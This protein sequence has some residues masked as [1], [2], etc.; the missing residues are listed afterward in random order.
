M[1]RRMLTLVGLFIATSAFLARAQRAEPV[2]VKLPLADLPFS[3]SDWRGQDE[4]PF[5]PGIL[6]ILGVDEYVTRSYRRNGSSVGLYVGYYESQRQGDTVHSPL[7][8]LPGAGWIPVQQG[9]TWLRVASHGA[10]RDIEINRVIIQK[11]LDR[12][13]VLYWYQSHGRVVAS[14]Y[15]GKIY[16]VADAIRYNKTDAALIRVIV[17]IGEG[18]SAAVAGADASGAAFVEALFPALER[19]LPS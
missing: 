16:T 3:V 6:A 13:L 9:R 11:G 12:N 18:G 4:R 7:N 19:H 17:P 14:E 8:C 5:E 2:P 15:R 1:T 10:P